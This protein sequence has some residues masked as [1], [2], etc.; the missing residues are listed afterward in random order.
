MAYKECFL[1]GAN[2]TRDPLDTHH[3]FGGSNRKKSDKY[4]LVVHLC[5][6]KCHIF[7]KNAVHNN[8]EIR[9]QLHEYGQRKVMAEQGWTVDEFRWEFGKNYIDEEETWEAEPQRSAG[10]F[11]LLTDPMPLPF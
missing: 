2:G 8:P 10:G 4:G 3:I 7:G 5:H 1:C 6:H 9:Q 11:T